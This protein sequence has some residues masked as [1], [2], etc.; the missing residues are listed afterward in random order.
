MF[1]WY[2]WLFDYEQP[3][4]CN[5]IFF[6]LS[7]FKTIRFFQRYFSELIVTITVIVIV[8]MFVK[9]IQPYCDFIFTQEKKIR[10]VSLSKRFI[11]CQTVCTVACTNVRLLLSRSVRSVTRA[12]ETHT[13]VQLLVRQAGCSYVC[14]F[15]FVLE[16]NWISSGSKEGIVANLIMFAWA[17]KIN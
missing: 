13:W 4:K 11:F 17:R 10:L 14:N 6:Q 8:I 1:E 9:V 3:K 12:K 16:I 15:S 5:S 2:R 7:S